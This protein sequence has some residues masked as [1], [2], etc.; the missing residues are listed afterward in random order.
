[1]VGHTLRLSMV[2]V[3]QTRV[4]LQTLASHSQVQVLALASQA[5][6]WLLSLVGQTCIGQG[7]AT[8]YSLMASK[9]CKGQGLDSHNASMLAKPTK[10]NLLPPTTL[11]LTDV[12]CALIGGRSHQLVE[13]GGPRCLK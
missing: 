11:L 1:M 10:G 12:G 6:T 8:H 13:F 4:E 9:T 2:K 3:G 5:Y 7:L